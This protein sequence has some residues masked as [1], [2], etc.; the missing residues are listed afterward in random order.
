MNQ[1][2]II[3]LLNSHPSLPWQLLTVSKEP[4]TVRWLPILQ[5]YNKGYYLGLTEQGEWIIK[6]HNECI[7]LQKKRLFVPLLP[8]LELEYETFLTQ[9]KINLK[10]LTLPVSLISAFPWLEML[11]CGLEQHS[12]YWARRVLKWLESC[13]GLQQAI[14]LVPLLEQ[15]S[16]AKWA[17]QK[18]RQTCK[19]VLRSRKVN[20]PLSTIHYPLSAKNENP[21][22]PANPLT[23]L[24]SI[25][26]LVWTRE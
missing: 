22:S 20:Y 11:I 13:E 21:S 10:R 1:L 6:V 7:R 25:P 19:Q 18:V 23:D 17:S 9:L 16:L 3:T 14:E 2:D 26:S 15:V 24:P 4:Q 12:D 5:V 8:L